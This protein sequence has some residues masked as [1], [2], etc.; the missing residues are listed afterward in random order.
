MLGEEAQPA[1]P[2]P[3]SHRFLFLFLCGG[4]VSVEGTDIRTEN[5]PEGMGEIL[6]RWQGAEAGYGAPRDPE[7]A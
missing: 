3:S 4:V 6:R 5:E 7:G 1:T 2:H